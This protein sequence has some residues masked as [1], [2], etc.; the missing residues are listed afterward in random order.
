[1]QVLEDE[2]RVLC[3][4]LII[5]FVV[6]EIIFRSNDFLNRRAVCAIIGIEQHRWGIIPLTVQFVVHLWRFQRNKCVSL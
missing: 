2:E 5:S 6:P 4:K 3:F 1:M